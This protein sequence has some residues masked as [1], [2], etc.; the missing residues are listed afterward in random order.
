LWGENYKRRMEVWVQAL[1]VATDDTP[2]R[3]VRPCDIQK[4][5]KSSKLRWVCGI[6]GIPNKCLRQGHQEGHLYIWHIYLVTAF[7]CRIFQSLGR[8]KNYNLIEIL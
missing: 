8:G 3:K 7:G 4:I 2:L 6:G 5:I 1:L